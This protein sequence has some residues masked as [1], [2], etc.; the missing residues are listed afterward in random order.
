VLVREQ[1][2]TDD[3]ALELMLRLTCDCEVAVIAADGS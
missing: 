2:L 1:H 3:Q